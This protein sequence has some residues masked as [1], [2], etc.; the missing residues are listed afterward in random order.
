MTI[1]RSREN[2]IVVEDHGVSRVHAIVTRDEEG[3]YRIR[4]QDSTNG[5]YVNSQR[6]FEHVLEDDDEIRVGMTELAFRQQ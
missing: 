4:D 1:G 5:T 3:N 6:I 2:D